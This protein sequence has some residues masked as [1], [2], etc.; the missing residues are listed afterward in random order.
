M[1]SQLLY[2]IILNICAYVW[3]GIYSSK[4]L[5]SIAKNYLNDEELK[6]QLM[7]LGWILDLGEPGKNCKGLC[8]I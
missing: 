7:W 4:I 1:F 8:P 3:I 5:I 6:I 2:N